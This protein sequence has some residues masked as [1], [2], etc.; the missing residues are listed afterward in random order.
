[1]RK[2]LFITLAALVTAP[3][4]YGVQ[5]AKTY[6]NWETESANALIEHAKKGELKEIKNII[7]NNPDIV[8]TQYEK[9]SVA[10]SAAIDNGHAKVVEYL[11]KEKYANVDAIKVDEML[12]RD[13]ARRSVQTAL[14]ELL[15]P[16]AQ[17]ANNPQVLK[18]LEKEQKK[19]SKL[20]DKINEPE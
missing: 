5:V 7:K 12:D 17:A 13:S 3:Y 8:Q 1:M 16:L 14:D 20:R 15:A 6:A 19:L 11:I 2:L 10:V 9:I 4:G 18:V